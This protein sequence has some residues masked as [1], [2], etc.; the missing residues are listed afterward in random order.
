MAIWRRRACAIE[1]CSRVIYVKFFVVGIQTIRAV[2][3][4]LVLWFASNVMAASAKTGEL[5]FPRP[6]TAYETVENATAW[7]TIK[8]R[9]SAEPLNA[10]VSILFLCAIIHTFLAPKIL[11]LSHQLREGHYK[12][13]RERSKTDPQ[14]PSVSFKAEMLHFLGEI[15]AVF[16]IWVIPVLITIAVMKGW[17]VPMDYIESLSFAEPVFVVVIMVIASTRPVLFVAE[18]CLALVVRLMGGSIA[19]WWFTL[20]TIGPLLGSFITEPGAMT[21][22]ALLLRDKFFRHRPPPV[23]AYATVGLLFMNVSIGGALTNFAAPPIL[24]VA[25]TWEWSS[26]YVLT[27]F[28]AKSAISILV[29]TFL[30]LLFFRKSLRAMQAVPDEAAENDFQRR[31]PPAWI[32][33]AHLIALVWTVFASHYSPLVVGGFLIFLAFTEATHPHQNAIVLRPA[34]LVGFFLAGLVAHGG[35]QGW[36]IQ[37]VISS[38]GETALLVGSIILTSFNDNAAIT[39]L[40]SQVP[41]LSP[42]LKYAVVS[43][44]IIGGGL[45]VI[46]NAPNP[47]GQALLQKYFPEGLHPLRLFLGAL[48]PTIITA[49]IFLKF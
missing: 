11:H 2:L 16:G 32:T 6:T 5:A 22:S 35:L 44:A 34:L 33:V 19:A 17:H 39:Y 24:M 12:L 29:N 31:N 18:A 30:Y 14:F 20:M 25:R 43:G 10:I 42:A 27:T 47:A 23:F 41:N 15:E 28:G 38:L 21:I 48:I 4:G 37:P 26:G 40:A 36:W 45:T 3:F 46:A 9:A 7:E 13:F 8:A 49:L 1:L